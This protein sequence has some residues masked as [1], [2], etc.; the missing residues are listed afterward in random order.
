MIRRSGLWRLC[1]QALA[2]T[3]DPMKIG[4]VKDQTRQILDRIDRLLSRA[5]SDKS[6]LLSAQVWLTDMALFADH[7][8]VWNT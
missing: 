4:D 3:A 5:G 2:R 6:K 8:S 1:A 7:N